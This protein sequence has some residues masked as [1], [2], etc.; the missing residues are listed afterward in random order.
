[1][2]K[3]PPVNAGLRFSSWL[4]KIPLENEMAPHFSI[5]VWRIPWTEEPGRVQSMGLKRVGHNSV[6]NLI[7]L[8]VEQSSS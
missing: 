7:I 2:V 3:N 6:T 1:M 5:I 8:I 4:G